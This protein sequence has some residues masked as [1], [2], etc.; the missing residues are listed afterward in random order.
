M[1]FLESLGIDFLSLIG[2]HPP[3]ISYPLAQIKSTVDFLT[4]MQFTAPELRRICNMVP[5]ILTTQVK[6][7]IAIFTFLLREARVQGSDLKRV[8]NRR[9]RLLASDVKTRLRP[10]LYF[11]QSIG[12]A[13]VYRH[14]NLLSCSVEQKLLL[15]IE[16]LEK[17]GF[18]HREALVMVRR[19]PQMFCYS[20]KGNFEPKTDYFVEEMRRELKE[21]QEFPQYYSFSLENRIKPRHQ[22]CVEKGVLLPLKLML[23]STEIEFRERL[24]VC[25]SSSL[26]LRTSPL[27]CTN[28]DLTDFSIKNI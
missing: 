12:I 24:E 22:V 13:E 3:V 7:V 27:W 23:K 4:S 9:P 10:T 19:F 5:E 17:V 6:D 15:R 20:I 1:L 21:L 16:F 25:Y 2:S 26:P 18:T 28:C 8:I 14:T 11:L